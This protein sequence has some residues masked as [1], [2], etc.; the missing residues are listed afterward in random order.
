V[1]HIVGGTESGALHTPPPPPSRQCALLKRRLPFERNSRHA[2]SADTHR[3]K[4][5]PHSAMSAHHNSKQVTPPLR[6]CGEISLPTYK[7]QLVFTHGRG[8]YFF[9]STG[10]KYLDFLGGIAVTASATRIPNIIKVIRASLKSDPSLQSFFSPRISG[11]LARSLRRNLRYGRVFFSNSGPKPSQAV[12]NSPRFFPPR[13]C[14]PHR[15]EPEAS[16]FS[17]SNS[18][19][20]TVALAPSAIPHRKVSL[21]LRSARPG[22]EFVTFSRRRRP[23]S[24]FAKTFC[25]C[26]SSSRL[27]GCEVAFIPSANRS[28]IVPARSL[29]ITMAL[30]VADEIQ[31]GLGP[32]R[33]LLRLS[34]LSSKPQTL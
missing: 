23:Q 20:G 6:R 25:R 21:A 11:P 16:Q 5:L 19:H 28:G 3:R 7:R 31:C 34:K 32:Y 15:L 26:P 13:R 1:F 12:S 24:K 22:V 14:A 33:P 8:P 4:C 10:K 27:P 29:K 2:Y 9:D 17:R 30:L 18:F